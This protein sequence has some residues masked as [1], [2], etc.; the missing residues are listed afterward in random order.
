MTTHVDA[1]LLVENK[2]KL[3]KKMESY[4]KINRAPKIFVLLFSLNFYLIQTSFINLVH[5]I[6]QNNIFFCW[7]Q[8]YNTYLLKYIIVPGTSLAFLLLLTQGCELEWSEVEKALVGIFILKN[9]FTQRH[10]ER[11]FEILLLSPTF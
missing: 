10:R 9:S 7:K 8:Q 11:D 1:I 2:T 3:K 4:F 5:K 6:S